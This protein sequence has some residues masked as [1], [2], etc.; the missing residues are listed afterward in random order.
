MTILID[1]DGC[2]VVDLTLQI[3]KQFDVP[4]ILILWVIKS[5]PYRIG[6]FFRDCKDLKSP[7]VQLTTKMRQATH[8]SGI[9]SHFSV[10]GYLRY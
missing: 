5:K 7:S 2:P 4:V 3:A 9:L 6:T 1:A 8:L 10:G